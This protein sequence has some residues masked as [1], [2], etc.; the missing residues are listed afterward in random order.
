M[1]IE[2]DV[3]AL[4]VAILGWI[5]GVATYLWNRQ[6]DRRLQIKELRALREWFKGTRTFLNPPQ[7]SGGIAWNRAYDRIREAR[8]ITGETL[9]HFPLKHPTRSSLEKLRNAC[10]AFSDIWD[11]YGM[12]ADTHGG[13]EKL[14]KALDS[15]QETTKIVLMEI[16]KELKRTG[17]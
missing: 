16:E 6:Q 4:V 12:C 17:G 10:M 13:Q 9:V 2:V 1:N 8:R 7:E 11:E 3:A 14:M 15:L 5:V